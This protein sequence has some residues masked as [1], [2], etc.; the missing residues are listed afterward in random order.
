MKNHRL[1]WVWV[2]Y[3]L[4][5]NQHC[6]F[7]MFDCDRLRLRSR[8]LDRKNRSKPLFSNSPLSS[9]WALQWNQQFLLNTWNWLKGK[10]ATRFY[11]INPWENKNKFWNHRVIMVLQLWLKTEYWPHCVPVVL[12]ARGRSVKA[13][14]PQLRI[15]L[16]LPPMLDSASSAQHLV[17]IHLYG[18]NSRWKNMRKHENIIYIFCKDSRIKLFIVEVR[19]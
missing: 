6:F 14:R 8:Y 12:A 7:Q 17:L 1:G 9:W 11:L 16:L 18:V 13:G 3:H 15:P 5:L 4:A 19:I 2:Y 10:S